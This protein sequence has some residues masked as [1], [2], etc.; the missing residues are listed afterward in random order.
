M[1]SFSFISSFILAIFAV[2]V[3][4]S[5]L[6]VKRDDIIMQMTMRQSPTS[7]SE[8]LGDPIHIGLSPSAYDWGHGGCLKFSSDELVKSVLASAA[9]TTF[10]NNDEIT[11]WLVDFEKIDS[12]CTVGVYLPNTFLTDVPYSEQANC[13][14]LQYKIDQNGKGTRIPMQFLTEFGLQFC[15]G[16]DDCAAMLPA[17][18]QSSSAQSS[19][20]EVHFAET[21]GTCTAAVDQ[22]QGKHKKQKKKDGPVE[23]GAA[24]Q[25]PGKMVYASQWLDCTGQSES[26]SLAAIPILT[27]TKGTMSSVSS[28][29]GT[30]LQ[31]GGSTK[32][33][34]FI[35]STTISAT[36]VSS[37]T[38]TKAIQ[39]D[40]SQAKTE[41]TYYTIYCRPG[42][43]CA[44]VFTPR[45]SAREATQCL[46]DGTLRKWIEYENVVAVGPTGQQEVQG[47]Y[48]VIYKD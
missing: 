36:S 11:D 1:K 27:E 13:G 19:I 44:I 39:K 30:G 3:A 21:S 32:V 25:V 45:A 6:P 12:T 16:V 23:Y 2:A 10:V 20:A 29:A 34:W 5:V 7:V 46:K 42:Q 9:S 28:A 33:K 22:A 41:S 43:S 47:E 24:F 17:N 8:N 26:C 4:A 31:V 18:D 14:K 35:G 48:S 38:Y 40:H 15:C 37:Y